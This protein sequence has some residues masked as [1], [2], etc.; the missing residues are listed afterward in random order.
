MGLVRILALS[1]P[2]HRVVGG[3]Q[4]AMLFQPLVTT[5]VLAAGLLADNVAAFGRFGRMSRDPYNLAK[6]AQRA[7]PKLEQREQS[8]QS[9][10]FLNNNTKRKLQKCR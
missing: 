4:F 5:A 10:R 7:H 1:S 6:R 8:K 9:F 3:P 2:S